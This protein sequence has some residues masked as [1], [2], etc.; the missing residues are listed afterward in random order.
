MSYLCEK[1]PFKLATRKTHISKLPRVLTVQ[2]KRFEVVKSA[3]SDS[4]RASKRSDAVTLDS[5]ISMAKYVKPNEDEDK[6]KPYAMQKSQL[7]S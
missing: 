2:V 7:P 4:M 5:Q 1:C 6:V 3:Y